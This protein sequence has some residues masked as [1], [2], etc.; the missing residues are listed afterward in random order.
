MKQKPSRSRVSKNTYSWLQG[1]Q[2]SLKF[3]LNESERFM[4][5]IQLFISSAVSTNQNKTKQ[6]PKVWGKKEHH[7][8]LR[9]LRTI[10]VN[11][12]Q[13]HKGQHFAESNGTKKMDA[14]WWKEPRALH[15]SNS[16]LWKQANWSYGRAD[17]DRW[18][19]RMTKQKEVTALHYSNNFWRDGRT[20]EKAIQF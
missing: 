12:P 5:H 16:W 18:T 13:R 2:W 14:H 7:L 19:W 11:I 15:T 1:R 20:K 3:R 9:A 8:Y 4:L 10:E 6:N 17:N